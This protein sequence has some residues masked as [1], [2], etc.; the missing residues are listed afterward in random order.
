LAPIFLAGKVFS[1]KYKRIGNR[2]KEIIKSIE[3]EERRRQISLGFDRIIRILTK[4]NV[5][6]KEDLENQGIVNSSIGLP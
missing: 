1:L 2:M 3:S 4:T 5:S 6:K